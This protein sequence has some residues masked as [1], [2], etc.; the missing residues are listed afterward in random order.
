MNFKMPI[1]KGIL[2]KVLTYET[3]SPTNNPHPGYPCSVVLKLECGHEL[4]RKWSQGIPQRAKCTQCNE[5]EK[6]E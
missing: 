2:R 6:G 5:R 4:R 1:Q 3:Y